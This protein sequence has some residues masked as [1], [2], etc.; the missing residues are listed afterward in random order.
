M[1]GN[2]HSGKGGRYQFIVKI[3]ALAVVESVVVGGHGLRNVEV[4]NANGALHEI[5]D[6]EYWT[7]RGA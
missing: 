1:Q 6:I 7:V 5:L 2:E 3:E 4:R